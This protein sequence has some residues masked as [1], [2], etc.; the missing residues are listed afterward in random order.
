[1]SDRTLYIGSYGHRYGGD[2]C[3]IAVG[4]DENEVDDAV[5]RALDQEKEDLPGYCEI[6]HNEWPDYPIA[7]CELH[8]PDLIVYGVYATYWPVKHGYVRNLGELREIYRELRDRKIW[9]LER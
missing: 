1:M 4:F 9:W 5:R 3:G 2:P 8:N 6:P 7:Q